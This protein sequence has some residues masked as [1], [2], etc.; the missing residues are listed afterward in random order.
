MNLNKGESLILSTIR[1]NPGLG[2]TATMKV[3]FMVQD[4]KGVRA[5]YDFSIYTY[6]PYAAAVMEDIDY[7]TS[8]GLVSCSMYSSHTYI[9]YELNLLPRGMEVAPHL[10]KEE[11]NALEDVVN[12]AR[13]KSA[14]ELELY[15]TIIYIDRF[16]KKNPNSYSE[17]AI[18]KKVHEIKPHF[19]LHKIMSAY[20]ELKEIKYV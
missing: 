9:G 7:L 10:S 4:V 13:G 18:A 15:S 11:L 17:D 5:G 1:L 8:C 3:L 2:K 20:R 12:F 19:E 14:K 16:F 6:G